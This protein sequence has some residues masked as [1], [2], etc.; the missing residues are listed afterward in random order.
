MTDYDR[1][2]ALAAADGTRDA[3]A[4]LT[5]MLD[6]DDEAMD[7][8][9]FNADPMLIAASLAGFA[10]FAV[11]PGQLRQLIAA[12]RQAAASTEAEA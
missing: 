3:M 9:L 4:Y 7:A 8:V 6:R 11:D 2:A 5:A 10:I 12:W 1:E